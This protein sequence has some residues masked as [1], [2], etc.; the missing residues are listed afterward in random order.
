[1]IYRKKLEI[2]SKYNSHVDFPGEF[3]SPNRPIISDKSIKLSFAKHKVI[4]KIKDS[5]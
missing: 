5:F 1:M 3:D 4:E 2:S